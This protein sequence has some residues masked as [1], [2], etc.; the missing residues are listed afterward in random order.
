MPFFALLCLV[1][2]LIAALG[3]TW[4]WRSTPGP[5]YGGAAF[6]WGVFFLAVYLCWPTLKALGL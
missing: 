4:F 2:L 3:S 6:A 1:L 5:W